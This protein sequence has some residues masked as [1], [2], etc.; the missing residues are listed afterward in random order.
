CDGT[1]L[2]T[3]D[4]RGLTLTG[5]LPYFGGP[6]NSYSLHAIA[7]TVHAMRAAPGSFG[8]VA[9]N[10]GIMSK[11]SVG[12]YSTQAADWADGDSAELRAQVAGRPTTPIAHR[13]DGAATIETYTVRYDWPVRT[14]IIVGRRDADGSRFLAL[15]EDPDLVGLLSEAEP[16]GAAITVRHNGKINTAVLR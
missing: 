3:D 8:L 2:A 9:A 5:G 16:L 10:G 15:S 6:G 12:V 11:Y 7:E 4:P 1:G 13:A 14:G